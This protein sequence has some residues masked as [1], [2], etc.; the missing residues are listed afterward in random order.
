M[1][2][3]EPAK[4][5]TL[6]ISLSSLFETPHSSLLKLQ[7]QSSLPLLS[8]F[9]KISLSSYISS[10]PTSRHHVVPH[11][12]SKVLLATPGPSLHVAQHITEEIKTPAPAVS[13]VACGLITLNLL[14]KTTTKLILVGI[15]LLPFYTILNLYLFICIFLGIF[16][17]LYMKTY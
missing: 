15:L 13:H 2:L 10:P 6:P 14:A 9:C 1:S 11:P 3:R 17:K 12:P 8:I 7:S 4:P 5:I 16:L